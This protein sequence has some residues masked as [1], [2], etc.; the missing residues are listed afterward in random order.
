MSEQERIIDKY[1]EEFTALSKAEVILV[2]EAIS[3]LVNPQLDLEASFISKINST[4]DVDLRDR[5][6]KRINEVLNQEFGRELLASNLVVNNICK[7]AIVSLTLNLQ[8]KTQSFIDSENRE[9]YSQLFQ[10]AR[11]YVAAINNLSLATI[12]LKE[13]VFNGKGQNVSGEHMATEKPHEEYQN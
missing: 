2:H 11:N 9:I 13:R 12:D 6:T 10:S 4:L 7:E 3:L 1:I 8:V 5:L